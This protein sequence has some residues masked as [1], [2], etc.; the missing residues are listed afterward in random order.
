M[1]SGHR[2]CIAGL[3]EQIAVV[4]GGTRGIGLATAEELAR[5]GCAVIVVSRDR[6]A[7]EKV[8]QHL[9]QSHHVRSLGV[10]ADVAD[11]RSVGLMLDEV[12]A[13]GLGRIDI[14]V[15]NAGYPVESR[16]WD[17]PLHEMPA[18][19]LEEW[20]NT[21]A[22]VDVG[23]ARNVTHAVLPTMI[24]QKSGTLVYVSSTPALSGH[25]AT[26]Y[27][28]A[29]AAL[30]GLMRDVALNYG[31]SGIRANA[32]APGNI[33]TG[34]FE[35]LTVEEQRRLASEAYLKR[36]GEPQEVAKA[37]LFLASPLSSFIIG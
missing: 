11:R 28:E 2:T 5:Y 16:L 19:K 21:V 23:G 14:V 17:T 7:A 15:N 4:T 27:T 1:S 10:A 6:D 25:K 18:E 12:L 3:A 35:G 37:I 20:F 31:A 33:K 24:K 30:L 13:F 36:W 32:V 34:W 9:H 29:K 22:R 8:A 26:P